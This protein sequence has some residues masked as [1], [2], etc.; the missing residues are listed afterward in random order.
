ML[1]GRKIEFG[2]PKKRVAK[3][4]DPYEGL[5]VL[6]MHEKPESKGS[7]YKFELSNLA[8][9][10]LSLKREKAEDL[11]FVSVAFLETGVMIANTTMIA[12]EVPQDSLYNLS[13]AGI[14]SN[15]TLYNFLAE[16]FEL[17]TSVPHKFELVHGEENA[18]YPNAYLRLADDDTKLDET[19]NPE[20]E[21]NRPEG[22]APEEQVPEFES[23]AESDLEFDET[24]M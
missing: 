7:T 6:V 1:E 9:E 11:K 20:T 23:Q 3:K 5:T 8:L 15:K 13:M 4:E 16:K 18:P 12:D 24:P 22:G 21:E 2:V 17:D 14:F 10:K 19:A